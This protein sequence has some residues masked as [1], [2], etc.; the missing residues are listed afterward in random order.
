MLQAPD[1]DNLEPT[2]FPKHQTLADVLAHVHQSIRLSYPLNK[3]QSSR[4][5]PPHGNM[6]KSLVALTPEINKIKLVLLEP[7]ALGP[8]P[9]PFPSL[10]TETFTTKE[11]SINWPAPMPSLNETEVMSSLVHH[12]FEFLNRTVLEALQINGDFKLFSYLITKRDAD[13]KAYPKR[14]DFKFPLAVFMSPPGNIYIVFTRCL[15]NGDVEARITHNLCPSHIIDKYPMLRVSLTDPDAFVELHR[16][17]T[18]VVPLARHLFDPANFKKRINDMADQ[19][20]PEF[21]EQFL[22]E[23]EAAAIWLGK[24][25]AYSPGVRLSLFMTRLMFCWQSF[26][27]YLILFLIKAC[28]PRLPPSKQLHSRKG[29]QLKGTIV[30]ETKQTLII[31]PSPEPTSWFSVPRFVPG[32]PQQSASRASNDVYVYQHLGYVLKIYHDIPEFQSERLVYDHCKELQGSIIPVLFATGTVQGYDNP[33]ILISYEGE[34]VE[35]RSEHDLVV[36]RNKIR[37]LHQAG[38]HHND[39]AY[40]NIV[41][42]GD[43]I[44]IIDFGLAEKCPQN[45]SE[46]RQPLVCSHDDFDTFEEF[47]SFEE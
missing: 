6:A 31:S 10:G 25:P 27:K 39:L 22:N 46:D 43:D 9:F 23:V 7:A 5:R 20:S 29:H 18:S 34:S 35:N 8:F 28:L 4:S 37:K 41:G 15:D 45:R 33:F 21:K 42:K 11:G 32:V 2:S 3:S 13:M 16:I 30:L 36:I 47:E 19:V 40:R 44:K 26:V 17:L 1:R 14:T 38:I 12:P 24:Q